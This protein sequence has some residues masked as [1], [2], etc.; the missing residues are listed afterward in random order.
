MPGAHR[1]Y[2]EPY[3]EPEQHSATDVDVD[4]DSPSQLSMLAQ[5]VTQMAQVQI[6]QATR[7]FS[8][9]VPLAK[10]RPRD[11][12]EAFLTSFERSMRA[13]SVPPDDW[14][15]LLSPR[16]TDKALLAYTE[17]A[18]TEADSY[19]RVKEV[20]LHR[21]AVTPETRRRKFR[22][23]TLQKSESMIDFAIRVRDTGSCRPASSR[24]AIM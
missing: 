12:V 4:V 20:I 10:L 1:S 17:L 14:V 23:T 8:Q 6:D 2:S 22:G 19:D 5:L 18:F 13:Y 24:E 3:T 11:D 21:Y 15:Y 7:R 9:K 16:L